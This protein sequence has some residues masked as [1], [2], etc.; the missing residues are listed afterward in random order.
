MTTVI[1]YDEQGRAY[2]LSPPSEYQ[3]EDARPTHFIKD[4]RAKAYYQ[5]HGRW[6]K[7]YTH[8]KVNKRYYL[9]RAAYN[10]VSSLYKVKVLEANSRLY[11]IKDQLR[12]YQY[13]AVQ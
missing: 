3:V 5:T 6:V 2:T 10:E 4:P 1:N 11:H 12:D 8:D 13:E 9:P 7:L